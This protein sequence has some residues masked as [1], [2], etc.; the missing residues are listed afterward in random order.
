MT[1]EA[2]HRSVTHMGDGK[3]ELVWETQEKDEALMAAQVWSMF[4]ETPFEDDSVPLG[5]VENEVGKEEV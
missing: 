5:K 2:Q 3:S 4:G 1:N